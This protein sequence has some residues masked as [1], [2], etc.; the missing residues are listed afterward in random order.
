M[1]DFTHHAEPHARPS[2]SL[3]DGGLAAAALAIAGLIAVC[4]VAA[5]A[6]WLLRGAVHEPP[7]APAPPRALEAG[8]LRLAVDPAWTPAAPLA[9]MAGPGAAH[10]ATL[11]VNGGQPARAIV[12]VE[13]FADATLLPATLR[14]LASGELPAPLRVRMLGL[15]AWRYSGVP[16]GRGEM[17]VTVVPTTAGALAVACVVSD[18]T[19]STSLWCDGGVRG[20]DLRGAATLRPEPALALR[21]ALPDTIG[22]LN[23]RRGVLRERLERA[24]TR[25]GQARLSARLAR[26]YVRTAAALAPRTAGTT[27]GDHLLTGLKRT[28]AAYVRLTRATRAN[29]PRA[30]ARSAAAVRRGEEQVRRA[31]AALAGRL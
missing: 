12:T 25:R 22:R 10:G 5:G 8:G 6:G 16:V 18:A 7:A 28:S 9:G 15:P 13:P 1:G 11:A 21:A 27:A 26:A 3:R 4:A 29:R 23:G 30:Y 24:T 2:S 14:A 20:I 31:L 19:W 17:E